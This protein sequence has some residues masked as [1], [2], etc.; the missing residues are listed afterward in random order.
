MVRHR[1]R[2]LLVG[3]VAVGSISLLAGCSD[4]QE[5]RPP[6]AE[7]V[8]P[9][10]GHHYTSAPDSVVVDATDDRGVARV[11]IGLDGRLLSTRAT[12]PYSTRLPLGLYADGRPYE[13]SAR[14][15]DGRA[16]TGDAAP[17]TVTIDPQLQT[18]P[19]ITALGP[20]TD[21]DEPA[22]D[23]V[24]R[25]AWLPWP[26][27]LEHFAWE[28]ARDEYFMVSLAA[29]TTADTSVTVPLASVD[30]AY[31]RVR[32]VDGDEDSGWSRTARH[33]GLTTWRRHYS[34]PGPQ[35]G[36]GI[37]AAPDGGLRILSHGIAAHQV[38]RAAVQ[39]LAVSPTGDLLATTDLLT[40]DQP[41]TASLFA[42]DGRLYLAGLRADGGALLAAAGAEGDLLWSVDPGY[43]HTTGLALAADGTVLVAGA[44]RREG[45]PGGVIGSIADGGAVT[46]LLVF[47]LTAEREVHRAWRRP[48]G[49]FV[50]AGP[51]A[52]DVGETAGGIWALG[53]DAA[54]EVLWNVRLGTAHRWLL[55]GAGAREDAGQYVLG[56]IAMRADRRDR[57][58]FLVGL[59]QD[60]RIRWQTTDRG[61][62]LFADIRPDT[63]DR[64]LA[65]GAR[66]RDIGGGQ[67]E[68]DVA[69][70]GLSAFGATLWEASHRHG[71]DTQGWSLLPHPDGGWYVAGSRSTD[72]IEYDVELLC[73][74]DRGDLQ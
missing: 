72:G 42:P 46:E 34:L 49:G 30:L 20:P 37:A 54:G 45:R 15:Y 17:I 47:P 10:P 7:I 53:L 33:S 63:G 32:A 65:T 55:R 61:W 51:V 68:Y 44:D 3:L 13:L 8:Y 2:F 6:R 5:D 50:L 12:R 38:A 67:W 19:Q 28:L 48:G 74:D 62:H 29:G 39:L 9:E 14:A 71:R 21:L 52:P 73:V 60:G 57:Y 4:D 25:L 43:M 24:L 36:A 31:A 59:D 70:R 58:G 40:D 69:L 1:F 35:L 27:A 18:V 41:L 26:H 22:D 66:R 64:W 11:E 56:G 16:Q 23:P